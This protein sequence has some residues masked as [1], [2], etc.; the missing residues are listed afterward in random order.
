MLKSM[1]QASI[2]MLYQKNASDS[3]IFVLYQIW[4]I[5]IA[6][7]VELYNFI[8]SVTSPG[9]IRFT[10]KKIQCFFMKEYL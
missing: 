4:C 6:C 10:K 2:G 7:S 8:K 9:V 5:S 1:I 3:S